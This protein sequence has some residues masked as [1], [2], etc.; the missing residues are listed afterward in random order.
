[1]VCFLPHLRMSAT[2]KRSLKCMKLRSKFVVTFD[3]VD[4][5]HYNICDVL[6]GT[7]VPNGQ[8]TW[9][10]L[11]FSTNMPYVLSPNWLCTRMTRV[12]FD[13]LLS[14]RALPTVNIDLTSALTADRHEK[15]DKLWL[16]LIAE[17]SPKIVRITTTLRKSNDI[18]M[19]T[20]FSVPFPVSK[21]T[22]NLLTL[23]KR[24]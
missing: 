8:K 11:P 13:M 12:T 17:T 23:N 16:Y 7:Y 6:C 22:T 9:L 10:L 14:A 3:S 19:Y 18:K 2:K 15:Y 4:V 5:W 21:A 20:W 24:D 1:M